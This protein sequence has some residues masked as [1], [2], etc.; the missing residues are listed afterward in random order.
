[1]DKDKKIKCLT[2]CNQ[3][4]VKNL[5]EMVEVME[6]QN[7]LSEQASQILKVNI[8]IKFCIQYKVFIIY[9]N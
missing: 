3:K 2:E 5:K 4:L 7:M 9:L 8:Q 6:K 1:M